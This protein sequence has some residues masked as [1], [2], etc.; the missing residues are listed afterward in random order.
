VPRVDPFFDN[1]KPI[2]E[3]S[4]HFY[5]KSMNKPKMGSGMPTAMGAPAP[6]SIRQKKLSH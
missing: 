3:L 4:T 1:H 6:Q 5:A 2:G